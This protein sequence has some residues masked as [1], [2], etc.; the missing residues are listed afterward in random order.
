MPTAENDFKEKGVGSD[1][2]SDKSWMNSDQNWSQ[3]KLLGG[4][5]IT[6]ISPDPRSLPPQSETPDNSLLWIGLKPINPNFLYLL[7]A[8]QIHPTTTVRTRFQESCP[9]GLLLYIRSTPLP[10]LGGEPQS[11]APVLWLH[12]LEEVLFHPLIQQ[13]LWRCLGQSKKQVWLHSY[14]LPLKRKGSG[15][16]RPAQL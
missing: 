13:G 12:S 1:L 7:L 5:T 6:V 15:S 14:R 2:V 16:P 4:L 9:W 11:P 10:E 3:T 8:T